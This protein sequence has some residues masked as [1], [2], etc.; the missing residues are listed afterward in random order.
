VTADSDDYEDPEL[1]ASWLAEQRG[2]VQRYL[3]RQGVNHRGVSSEA[4]WFAR[5]TSAVR[6][7]YAK[8][9]K[10]QRNGARR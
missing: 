3:Q 1:E 10:K 2:N 7:P 6:N 8:R 5:K 9:L 4:V